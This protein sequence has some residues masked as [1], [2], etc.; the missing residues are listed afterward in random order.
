MWWIEIRLKITG[1]SLEAKC[2]L[3]SRNLA[4]NH[5]NIGVTSENRLSW[6]TLCFYSDRQTDLSNYVKSPLITTATRR[7]S[8]CKGQ[9][10]V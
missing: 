6:N 5:R 10:L 3:S 4:F 8:G 7:L 1:V 2:F 9:V